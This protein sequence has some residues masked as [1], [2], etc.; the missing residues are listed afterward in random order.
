MTRE[1]AKVLS[2]ILANHIAAYEVQ[3]GELKVP[4]IQEGEP[5]S[6]PVEPN[7]DADVKPEAE[8]TPQ[9]P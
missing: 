6:A 2:V 8:A 4:I 5:E 3:V 9:N 7:A 1:I